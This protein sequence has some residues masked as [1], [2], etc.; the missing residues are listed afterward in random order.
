MRQ[1]LRLTESDIYRIITES[2][3]HILTEG[4]DTL[5]VIYSKYYQDIPSEA[6]NSII[7]SDPTWSIEKKDKMGKYSKWLLGL[8]R[9]GKLKLEDL[10][11]AKLY[12]T[13]FNKYL[14]R[15]SIK[16]INRFK[17]LPELYNTVSEFIE[18]DNN[19]QS[20]ATSKSDEVRRIKNNAKKIYEDA[21]WLILIPLTREAA[22]YYGK[23]TQWCT[24]AERSSNYYDRYTKEGPLYIN[25]DKKNNRKYQFH[26]ESSQFMDEADNEIENPI[27]PTIG[28]GS[29]VVKKAY[30]NQYATLM[31]DSSDIALGNNVYLHKHVQL[32]CLDDNGLFS[33]EY[34]DFTKRIIAKFD[35]AVYLEDDAIIKLD[36]NNMWIQCQ[37]GQGYGGFLNLRTKE[38]ALDNTYQWL[39]SYQKQ[40]GTATIYGKIKDKPFI[41]IF[42][43]GEIKVI[44]YFKNGRGFF[45]ILG[46]SEGQYEADE[47]G[48]Q[49]YLTIS[50]GYEKL[51]VSVNEWEIFD[52]YDMETNKIVL[53][54]VTWDNSEASNNEHYI[55]LVTDEKAREF[56]PDNETER[57]YIALR[58]PITNEQ[59]NE[60]VMEKYGFDNMYE[61]EEDYAYI[62][63]EESVNELRNMSQK[64]RVFEDNGE[65]Q[66]VEN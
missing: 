16:D 52:V 1:P 58:T 6:F 7:E 15:I 59:L 3:Y 28:M 65:I 64:Y 30:P 25:I 5:D 49:R 31:F 12:L 46:P 18:A 10:Y 50:K 27:A 13:Y 51:D 41:G 8:Y 53:T 4:A 37:A 35:K 40:D 42:E 54:N 19:N 39:S 24:A 14:N 38:F 45:G 22:I 57:W 63:W 48:V 20:I 26:F 47:K 33:G 66:K 11:K 9:K 55:R 61:V 60:Y 56:L 2:I 23:N 34:G 44:E 43:D 29:E 32:Y 21:N 17:S 62:D 36:K